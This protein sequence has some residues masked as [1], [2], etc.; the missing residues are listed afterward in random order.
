MLN[1][2]EGNIHR[3]LP[4]LS[5]ELVKAGAHALNSIDRAENDLRQ[6]EYSQPLRDEVWAI[7]KGEMAYETPQEKIGAL[8][9]VRKRA[10]ATLRNKKK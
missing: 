6:I 2:E 8:E 10:W 3:A 9:S 7:L 4:N 1:Q 5:Q